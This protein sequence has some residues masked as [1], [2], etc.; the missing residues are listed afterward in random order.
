MR[1]WRRRRKAYLK[2]AGAQESGGTGGEAHRLRAAA[3]DVAGP[4]AGDQVA[5]TNHPWSFSQAALKARLGSSGF[6]SSTTS[7]RWPPPPRIWG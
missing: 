4:V 2:Q 7:P 6:S 3:I 5:L 1:G